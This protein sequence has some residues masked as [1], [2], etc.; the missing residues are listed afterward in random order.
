VNPPEDPT[1]EWTQAW[2]TVHQ[3][4]IG[5]YSIGYPAALLDSAKSGRTIVLN[6]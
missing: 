3:K 5:R 1:A 2:V 6:P 4:G